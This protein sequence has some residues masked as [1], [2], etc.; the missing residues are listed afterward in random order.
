MSLLFTHTWNVWTADSHRQVTDC[1]RTVRFEFE[2]NF[3]RWIWTIR[4][5]RHHVYTVRQLHLGNVSKDLQG[6]G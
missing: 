1:D 2:G 3:C 4:R 5:I 6:S